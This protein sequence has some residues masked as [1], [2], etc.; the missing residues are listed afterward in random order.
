MSSVPYAATLNLEGVPMKRIVVVFFLLLPLALLQGCFGGGGGGGNSQAQ[1]RLVNGTSNS[2]DLFSS[3]IVLASGVASATPSSYTAIAAGTSTVAL[4]NTGTGIPLTQTNYSFSGG[5]D[6]TIL[7]YTSGQNLHMVSFTDNEAVPVSGYGKLRIADLSSDAGNLDVYMAVQNTLS[8]TYAPGAAS[9]ALSA[10]AP[11]MVSSLSGTTGYYEIPQGTYHIWVTGAGDITDLRLDI[12]SVTIGN[13]Q[14]LT[15]ALTG[16]SS[17]VLVD[18][19]LVTQQGA[20]VAQKN[21]NVRVRIAANTSDIS[22]TNSVS[23][24]AGGTSLGSSATSPTVGSYVLVPSGTLAITVNGGGCTGSS[25]TA[26]AGEDLTLL[27]TGLTSAPV[28][29][30]IVDDNT[31]PAGGT[32]KLRVVNGVNSGGN[33][34]L[35]YDSLT[36]ASNVAFGTASSATAGTVNS[37]IVATIAVNSGSTQLYTTSATLES[38]GVYS[39]FML[40]NSGAATSVLILD[41]H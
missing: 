41:H 6:Y 13:Q 32:A 37:G 27:V 7:A 19:L 30:A 21:T 12:P 10:A 22:S 20:V 9:P 36:L 28:C 35:A 3:G 31:R 15:V 40:G 39:V 26:T 17:G 11:A 2:L 34:S 25:I 14:I 1:V 18:G 8:D 38:Q 16:T 23:V 29:T 24:S 33:I 4:E 5:V